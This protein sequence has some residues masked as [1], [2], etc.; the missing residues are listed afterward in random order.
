M[1]NY[2]GLLINNSILFMSHVRWDHDTLNVAEVP[3]ERFDLTTEKGQYY[4]KLFSSWLKKTM[5]D[6]ST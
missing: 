6:D 2:H 1:P 4:I 3:Y 5:Q